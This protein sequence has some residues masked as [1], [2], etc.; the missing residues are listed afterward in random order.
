MTSTTAS[1]FFRIA[2]P[3]RPTFCM[4]TF[5][6][7]MAWRISQGTEFFRLKRHYDPDEL[8]QNQF[9]RRYGQETSGDVGTQAN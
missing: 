8:F 6:R 7:V 9:Y 5:C 1:R 4:N 2:P 3:T